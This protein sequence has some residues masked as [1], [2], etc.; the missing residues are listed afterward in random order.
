MKVTKENGF[1]VVDDCKINKQEDLNQAVINLAEV[2]ER[3]IKNK[4]LKDSALQSLKQF[5]RFSNWAIT[6]DEL[7]GLDN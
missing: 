6:I 4:Y 3:S 7:R 1:I 5:N 2:I